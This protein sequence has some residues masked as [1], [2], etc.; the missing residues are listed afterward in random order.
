MNRTRLPSE[1]SRPRSGVALALLWL[2]ACHTHYR[3]VDD[4]ELGEGGGCADLADHTRYCWGTDTP[5]KSAK[6]MLAARAGSLPTAPDTPRFRLAG[7]TLCDHAAE[8]PV[9]CETLA[10]EPVSFAQSPHH[11]CVVNA[12]G[13]VLCRGESSKGRL[14]SG[15]TGFASRLRAVSGVVGAKTVALGDDFSCALLRNSTVS[16]WGSNERHQLAQPDPVVHDTPTPVVGLF[17]VKVLRAR[18]EQACASLTDGGLRCWGS[19]RGDG[20]SMGRPGTV[21]TVPMPVQFP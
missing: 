9:D 18:A 10:A 19:A 20:A 17:A 13:E 1:A 2:S 4:F 16:C 15:V 21:N 14:G 12:A 8:S 11:A 5:S 6:P 7:L 3:P